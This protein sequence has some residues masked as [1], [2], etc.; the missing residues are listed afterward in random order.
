MLT[1][2]VKISYSNL[3]VN[4]PLESYVYH[5]LMEENMDIVDE[6]ELHPFVMNIQGIDRTLGSF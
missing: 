6:Y 4:L 5:Y 3:T 1:K 2:G